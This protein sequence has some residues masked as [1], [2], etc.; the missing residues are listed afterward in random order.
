MERYCQN[1][2]CENEAV[3]QVP[4]S[5]RKVS[6]Q[7]RALCGPCEETYSWGVQH[8]QMSGLRIEPPPK[9]NGPERLYRAVYVID[10]NALNPQQ[11][12]ERVYEIMKDPESMLPVLDVLESSGRRTKVDL[13]QEGPT[14]RRPI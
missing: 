4:V 6:D 2:L 9:E 8:G 13:S 11:A 12:A 5:V 14:I 7:K 3:K 1:P 10:V